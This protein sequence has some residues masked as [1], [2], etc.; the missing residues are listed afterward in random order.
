MSSWSIYFVFKIL[1]FEGAYVAWSSQCGPPN[2]VI[3]L[4]FILTYPVDLI[5]L[6]FVVMGGGVNII[7]GPL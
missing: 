7:V 3:Y 2:F 6:D 1:K 4:C 5:R